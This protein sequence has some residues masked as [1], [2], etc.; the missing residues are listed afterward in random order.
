MNTAQLSIS[1]RG[2]EPPQ[3]PLNL[4]FRD[5]LRSRVIRGGAWD[6]GRAFLRST[7]R[8]KFYPLDS[9]HTIGFRVVRPRPAIK[10]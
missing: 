4:R 6:V 5:V 2:G 7:L 8:F 1:N 3:N 9:T 10:E